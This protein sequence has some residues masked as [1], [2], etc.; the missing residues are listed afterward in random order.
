MSDRRPQPSGASSVYASLASGTPLHEP[1]NPILAAVTRRKMTEKEVEALENR[2]KRL[3]VEEAKVKK[4]AMQARERSQ[5]NTTQARA[6]RIAEERAQ[7]ARARKAEADRLKQA[8]QRRKEEQR[9]NL[10]RAF[11][12]MYT[13]KVGDA[14]TLRDEQERAMKEAAR[15][16][17]RQLEQ[18][19]ERHDEIIQRRK[20]VSSRL[21]MQRI[22]HQVRAAAALAPLPFRYSALPRLCAGCRSP[23]CRQ[24]LG[25]RS[26]GCAGVPDA[27]LHRPDPDRDRGG[28][29]G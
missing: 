29:E 10:Q 16:R 7:V 17:E 8:A 24:P 21:E 1:T 28:R 19:Y 4:S 26:A 25:A 27:G 18:S 2:I 6:K 23:L 20:E 11:T 14:R 3:E 12:G 5:Q 15:I 13:G 9:Q 22:A